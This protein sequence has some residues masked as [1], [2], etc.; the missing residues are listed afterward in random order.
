M[1]TWQWLDGVPGLTKGLCLG[2]I[3]TLCL[4]A[5][6]FWRGPERR[7]AALLIGFGF[8]FVMAAI[9]ADGFSPA[10]YPAVCTLITISVLLYGLRIASY[11]LAASAAGMVAAAY[12]FYS[13]I[14]IP[15]D[16]AAV[17]VRNPINW[18]RV[19]LFTVFP[20]AT[21]AVA[22]GY[23]VDKLRQTLNARSE[24]VA[25][26]RDEV[27]QRERTLAELEATQT[28]LLQTQ[29]IEAIGQLA[30]GIAHDF[31]NTLSV[32]AMEAEL[33]KRRHA[34]P[35]GVV[36]SAEAMLSAAER[37]S[38]LTRQ[39]LLFNRAEAA[40]RPIIDV[41][42][43]FEGCVQVL[44]R[45]L[46]SEITCQVESAT[47]PMH[48]CIL[49]GELQQIVLNLGINARDA[50]PSGG[51]LHLQL[52]P[53]ELTT[54]D[55]Q[56]LGVAAGDYVKFSCRDTGAGMDPVTLSRVFEPFFTTKQPGRG[57]G[58]GLTTVWG[59]AQRAHGCIH[60]D[61]TPDI[62][63]QIEVY[64]PLSAAPPVVAQAPLE[65]AAATNETILVVEDDI[66]VRALLVT[67]LADAGY[68]VLEA[69]SADAALILERA[70]KGPID[71]VCTDVVMPG[72]PA[73]ELLAEMQQ[74]RP[75]AGVLVCSGYS[76]DER[77]ARGISS[78]EFVH[79][80]KPFTRAA[81][82]AAVREALQTTRKPHARQPS[83]AR[84]A[85]AV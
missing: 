58:L 73:R 84:P 64:L 22:T 36:Q 13:G 8:F 79:L 83:A 4:S 30:A 31:N 72:K 49:P 45:L 68:V 17:D 26:L 66:R 48:V 61:S 38:Q 9:F 80:G 65:A 56:R 63:T 52:E 74:R 3:S 82:L 71:L 25:R 78:G 53:S 35:A 18:M 24:L 2:Y 81:L 47:S 6:A 39:L 67:L 51:R 55:A 41:V 27:A 21:A 32:I 40:R 15:I 59:I 23:L 85:D 12:L 54:E 69:Q 76:E 42:K 62:G 1:M 14:L 77:I 29:K 50:M 46:P 37:G 28:R 20:S 19:I 44:T 7:R 11:L 75:G 16:P 5:L 57:S 70:H 10:Q 33:L 43:A 60:I 34:E